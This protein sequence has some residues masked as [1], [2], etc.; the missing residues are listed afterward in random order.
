MNG[1]KTHM[2]QRVSQSSKNFQ[3]LVKSMSLTM[4][5]SLKGRKIHVNTAKSEKETEQ[6]L[7]LRRQTKQ[8]RWGLFSCAFT[9]FAK[10]ACRRL[11]ERRWVHVWAAHTETVYPSTQT[12]SKS[13]RNPSIWNTPWQ[14]LLA[15]TSLEQ[16]CL[17]VYRRYFSTTPEA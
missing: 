7:H 10:Q 9:T 2:A 11:I 13:C 6:R 4:Y 8:T 14:F 3:G 1:F 12:K 16:T 5:T 17:P 15:L